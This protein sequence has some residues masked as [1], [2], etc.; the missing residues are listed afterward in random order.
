MNLARIHSLIL[1]HNLLRVC[2]LI[3]TPFVHFPEKNLDQ[4]PIEWVCVKLFSISKLFI[5]TQLQILYYDCK[6]HLQKH[7]KP[8]FQV[9]FENMYLFTLVTAIHR[10]ALRHLKVKGLSVIHLMNYV[11]KQQPNINVKYN[12]CSSILIIFKRL[13]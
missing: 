12:F 3:T 1:H 11:I 7:T 9:K 13:D 5:E 8:L 2:I 6:A 4:F 10:C